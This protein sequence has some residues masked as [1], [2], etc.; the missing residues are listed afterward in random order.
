MGISAIAIVSGIEKEHILKLRTSFQNFCDNS[1]EVS[2]VSRAD[3]DS[4]LKSLE[5]L[6]PSDVELLD[7]L[8]ILLDES[9]DCKIDYKDFLVGTAALI[10]GTV[11][12]KILFAFNVYDE[13]DS[14]EVMSGDM[15]KIFTALNAVASFFGDP[16]MTPTQIKELVIDVFKQGSSPSAPLRYEDHLEVISSHPVVSQFVNGKGSVRFGR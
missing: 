14:G 13:S 3:F 1:G 5:G 6:E 2:V 10:T 4:A 7:R 16:V 11:S 15:K 12:E 8:F 9:G